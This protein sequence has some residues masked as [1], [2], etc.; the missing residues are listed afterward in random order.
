MIVRLPTS[1]VVAEAEAIHSNTPAIRNGTL[2]SLSQ[3]SVLSET[4]LYDNSFQ[5]VEQRH[6]RKQVDRH[7]EQYYD[8]RNSPRFSSLNL[9]LTREAERYAC[10]FTFPPIKNFY[11]DENVTFNLLSF[12]RLS[13]NKKNLYLF[14]DDRD[15][16]SRLLVDRAYPKDICGQAY[17]VNYPKRIPPQLCLLAIGVPTYLTEEEIIMD[18]RSQY[19][20]ASV[21]LFDPPQSVRSR[22]V[23]I[24]FRLSEEYSKCLQN[25]YIYINHQKVTIK[26]Y[27]G[28][29]RVMICNKC[30]GFGHFRSKCVS[31]VEYCSKSF[32]SD[33]TISVEKSFI[34][35]TPQRKSSVNQPPPTSS[36]QRP[37]PLMSLNLNSRSQ[38]RTYADAAGRVGTVQPDPP[39]QYNVI[40]HLQSYQQRLSAIETHHSN[41]MLL[42][43]NQINML[44][45][46]ADFISTKIDQLSQLVTRVIVP[47]I[48]TLSNVFVRINEQFL[49][50][51]DRTDKQ[52]SSLLGFEAEAEKVKEMEK[53]LKE[54][55]RLSES[56]FS[57]STSAFSKLLSNF[58][59]SDT[60]SSSFLNTFDTVN[61]NLQLEQSC[62]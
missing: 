50:K 54:A 34:L 10:Q 41:Q 43:G 5:I 36:P 23:K 35:S 51:T 1:T 52:T 16:F 53:T 62:L 61:A 21:V 26:R 29:P 31:K 40:E 60:P 15:S 11:T 48:F 37:L 13:S 19:S 22:N 17:H 8:A 47:S 39:M 27:L 58:S 42:L 24:H 38:S 6:R 14:A 32:K 30:H 18:I 33:F 55:L 20:S 49:S 3:T 25:G 57:H 45:A 46:K 12:W 44:N 2:T 9:N 28:T 7:T 59:L 4:E 56:S